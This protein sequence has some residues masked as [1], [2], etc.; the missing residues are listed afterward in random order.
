MKYIIPAVYFAYFHTLSQGL[1]P[2]LMPTNRKNRPSQRQHEGKRAA[3]P[4]RDSKNRRSKKKRRVL[5]L[6]P[7]ADTR[8]IDSKPLERRSWRAIW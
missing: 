1:A 8:K 6:T 3:W 5:N 4:I 2:K 7:P